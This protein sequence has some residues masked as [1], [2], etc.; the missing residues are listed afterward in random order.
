MLRQL[1][2]QGYHTAYFDRYAQEAPSRLCFIVVGVRVGWKWLLRSIQWVMSP[3]HFFQWLSCRFRWARRRRQQVWAFVS[4]FR[5]LSFFVLA[6][7]LFF[8]S[9]WLFD[10]LLT[11][12]LTSPPP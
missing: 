11:Y 12:L 9:F 3:R 6:N 7:V 1:R 10:I 5:L 8:G 2:E 4:S